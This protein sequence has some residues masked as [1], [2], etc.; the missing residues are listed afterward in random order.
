MEGWESG[1]VGGDV[2][3]GCFPVGNC[4]GVE[5]C[6]WVAMEECWRRIQFPGTAS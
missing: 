1:D 3:D 2:G 6:H 4:E 5:M